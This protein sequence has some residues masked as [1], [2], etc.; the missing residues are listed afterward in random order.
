MET[1]KKVSSAPGWPRVSV[2]F[3][4]RRFLQDHQLGQLQGHPGSRQGGV[5]LAAW[6][7][8]H[9]APAGPA[10]NVEVHTPNSEKLWDW[11]WFTLW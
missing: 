5:V 1:P 10:E 11:R 4:A 7:K 6:R 8:T 2:D 9:V 3:P